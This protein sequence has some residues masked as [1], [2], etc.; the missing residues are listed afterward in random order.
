MAFSVGDNVKWGIEDLFISN[1]VTPLSLSGTVLAVDG[2]VAITLP[3]DDF[4][5]YSTG[6]IY[7]IAV[8]L[9]DYPF[10]NMVSPSGIEFSVLATPDGVCLSGGNIT[11]E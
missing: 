8:I 11:S 6:A 4:K 3:D 2:S 9:D 10:G 5:P 7:P 1:D